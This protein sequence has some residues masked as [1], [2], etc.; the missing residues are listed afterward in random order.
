MTRRKTHVAL[1]RL[2]PGTRFGVSVTDCGLQIT[3]EFGWARVS[4][5]ETAVV[6]D[7]ISNETARYAYLEESELEEH[8]YA[9]IRPRA[10]GPPPAGPPGCPG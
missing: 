10:G 1:V 9:E 4:Y 5:V 6:N 8:H 3:A 7:W 2:D